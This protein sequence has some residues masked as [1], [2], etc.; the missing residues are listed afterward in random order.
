MPESFLLTEKWVK[1]QRTIK[2]V[3]LITRNCFI[4]TGVGLVFLFR[5]YRGTVG[6]YIYTC[7][8]SAMKIIQYIENPLTY[9]SACTFI[10]DIYESAISMVSVLSEIIKLLRCHF[11]VKS[12]HAR[13]LIF[14]NEFFA[15]VMNGV[16]STW[17]MISLQQR[18]IDIPCHY[19]I[20]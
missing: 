18:F 3:L 14:I 10:I 6:Q 9:C 8:Q 15:P 7:R 5:F 13:R 2:G 17:V 4:G 1:T 16:N 11:L 20:I 19:K 12:I